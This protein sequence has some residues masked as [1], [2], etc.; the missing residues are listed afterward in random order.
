MTISSAKNIKAVDTN[1]SVTG[2]IELRAAEAVDMQATQNDR[3]HW[4]ASRFDIRATNTL[5]ATG[6]K[7]SVAPQTNIPEERVWNEETGELEP[8]Y[9]ALTGAEVKFESTAGQVILTQSTIQAT[10]ER[11]QREQPFDI[12][13]KSQT[14][15]LLNQSSITADDLT[16]TA[17]AG[18]INAAS[19]D[20]ALT[21]ALTLNGAN[22]LNLSGTQEEQGNFVSSVINLTTDEDLTLAYARLES[23]EGDITF[24]STEGELALDHV[25]L[26]SKTAVT[27]SSA[28]EM[29]L[30]DSEVTGT[31]VSL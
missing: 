1:L 7:L 6:V 11:T 13:V 14:D 19:A 23:T 31:K 12:E 4:T 5:N 22:G 8:H 16:V 3:G 15:T 27:L 26:E 20:I 17:T 30:T 25:T 28:A 24:N 21:G 29:T 18:Q 2:R 10:E 9:E